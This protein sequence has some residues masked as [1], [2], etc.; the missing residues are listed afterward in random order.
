MCIWDV[1]YEFT[2]W[3]SFRFEELTFEKLFEYSFFLKSF[4]K[5]FNC[6]VLK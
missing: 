6:I 1:N 5:T 2:I 4:L 3:R